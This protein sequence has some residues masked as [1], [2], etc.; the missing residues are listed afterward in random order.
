MKRIIE[1]GS[2]RLSFSARD[3]SS[4]TT[5]DKCNYHSNDSVFYFPPA[6]LSSRLKPCSLPS[7]LDVPPRNSTFINNKTQQSNKNID[8][9]FNANAATEINDASIVEMPSDEED[10]EEGLIV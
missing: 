9:F 1:S 6:H 10:I 8:G 3:L 2:S 7:L 5:R 4:I